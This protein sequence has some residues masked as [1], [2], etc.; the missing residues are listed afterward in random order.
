MYLCR[1]QYYLH[2]EFLDQ[3]KESGWALAFSSSRT[4]IMHLDVRNIF[5][6]IKGKSRLWTLNDISFMRVIDYDAQV[7]YAP[8]SHDITSLGR[9][10]S[11]CLQAII[12]E[13]QVCKSKGSVYTAVIN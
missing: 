11:A 13:E 10:L 2:E 4:E 8:N 12:L 6:S 5:I 7:L 9:T 1:N 3:T